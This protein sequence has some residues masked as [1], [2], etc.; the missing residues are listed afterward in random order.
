MDYWW[1]GLMYA[2]EMMNMHDLSVAQQ[3]SASLL[4]F[5][6]PPAVNN[7]GKQGRSAPTLQKI[8]QVRV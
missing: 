4:S 1:K 8:G 5:L 7:D 6:K 3:S 2:N